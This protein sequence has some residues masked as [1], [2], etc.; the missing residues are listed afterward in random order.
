MLCPSLTLDDLRHRVRE[1]EALLRVAAQHAR[2]AREDPSKSPHASARIQAICR[3]VEDMFPGMQE[4]A[5]PD[6]EVLAAMEQLQGGEPSSEGGE[7]DVDYAKLGAAIE[8][9]EL[10]SSFPEPGRSA[11][12]RAARFLVDSHERQELLSRVVQGF[13]EL[14]ALTTR[15]VEE[16]QRKLAMAMTLDALA[17]RKKD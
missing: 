2:E 8:N 9:D 3:E 1:A 14:S 10:M 17:A 13:E 4:P 5:G 16:T 7:W 11:F 12:K 15:S 6:A